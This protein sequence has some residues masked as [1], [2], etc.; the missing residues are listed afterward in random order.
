[1][2][3]VRWADP[4]GPT[5]VSWEQNGSVWVKSTLIVTCDITSHPFFLFISYIIL[6]KFS[7]NSINISKYHNH[8]DHE[9]QKSLELAHNTQ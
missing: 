4:P 6:Y 9:L 3:Y 8:I 5:N 2:S 1:M 7:I